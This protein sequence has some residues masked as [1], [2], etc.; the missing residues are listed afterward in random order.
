MIAKTLMQ[1]L[2]RCS[3]EHV[4][5]EALV[6]LD[7]GL[8]MLRQN[9]MLLSFSVLSRCWVF[10]VLGLLA[11]NP[12]RYD[13]SIHQFWSPE[14]GLVTVLFDEKM[15]LPFVVGALLG[16]IVPLH[17]LGVI[18]IFYLMGQGA[19][20]V[21]FGLALLAGLFFA[22]SRRFLRRGM[23]LAAEIRRIHLWFSGMLFLAFLFGSGLCFYFYGAAKNLGLFQATM[24]VNRYEFLILALIV[25]YLVQMLVLLV[26]GHFYS[27]RS[28]DP[29]LWQVKFSSGPHLRSFFLSKAFK[30]DLHR[31]VLE[32]I[33]EKDRHNTNEVKGL[34]RKL[35]DQHLEEKTFL[36]AAQSHLS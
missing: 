35:I 1:V 36:Q 5:D 23:K 30:Q 28:Q 10:L 32:K 21:V 6:A 33:K 18:I 3:A 7:F 2:K 11:V 25:F 14:S 13:F 12:W 26:W 24:Y 20:H 16:T 27:R 15:F 17:S 22:E 4:R 9:L 29:S 8:G 34:P 31:V 19:F